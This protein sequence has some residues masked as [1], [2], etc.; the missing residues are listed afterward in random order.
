[1]HTTIRLLLKPTSEQHQA[2]VGRKP[3][4]KSRVKLHQPTYNPLSKTCYQCDRTHRWNQ[5]TQSVVQ[6]SSY[7]G[8][9]NADL[10]GS[11]NIRRQDLASR[12]MAAKSVPQPQLVQLSQ[13]PGEEKF[14]VKAAPV[15]GVNESTEMGTAPTHLPSTTFRAFVLSSFYTAPSSLSEKELSLFLGQAG[16]ER[17]EGLRGMYSPDVDGNSALVSPLSHVSHVSQTDS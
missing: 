7:A 12:G 10:N 16:L 4:E 5:K 13:P 9:L 11:Q 1:M 2:P 15:T 14:P 8:E 3:D 6:C 17:Q